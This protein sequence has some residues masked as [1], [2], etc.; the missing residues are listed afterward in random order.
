MAETELNGGET[1]LP[2]EQACDFEEEERREEEAKK[3]AREPPIVYKDL[4]D[5]FF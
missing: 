2:S 1:R 4:L 3:K 5:V